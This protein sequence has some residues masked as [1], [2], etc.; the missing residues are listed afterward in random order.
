MLFL[1][2]LGITGTVKVRGMGACVGTVKVRGRVLAQSKSGELMGA[3]AGAVKVRGMGA[4]AG[5]VKVRGMN[6][7]VCWR[8]QS[9]GIREWVHVLA[10][11]K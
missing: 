9:Q 5:A 6:G 4:C 3:C 2:D 11:S 7:C 8:S 1:C 10:Q